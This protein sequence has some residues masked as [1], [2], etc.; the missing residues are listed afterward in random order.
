M[1][2]ES[3]NPEPVESYGAAD[4]SERAAAYE[5]WLATVLHPTL[6]DYR[7]R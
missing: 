7:E 2:A 6:E 4:A 3:N 1:L 5:R